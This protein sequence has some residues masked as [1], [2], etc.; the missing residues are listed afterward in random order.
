MIPVEETRAS[1]FI[2]FFNCQ[3]SS[4]MNFQEFMRIEIS[5]LVGLVFIDLGRAE[6][7]CSS[8]SFVCF[9]NGE[10]NTGPD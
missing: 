9:L 10:R 6:P 3:C 7:L 5:L 8:S 1:E 4:V 2:L